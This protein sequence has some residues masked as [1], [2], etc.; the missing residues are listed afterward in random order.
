[1]SLASKKPKEALVKIGFEF[2]TIY[3]SLFYTQMR[4]N[5]RTQKT[6]TLCLSMHLNR[7]WHTSLGQYFDAFAINFPKYSDANDSV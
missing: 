1:M 3:A 6:P 4:V 2:K 5:A 7:N